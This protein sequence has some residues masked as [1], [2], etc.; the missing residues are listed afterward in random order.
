MEKILDDVFS[1]ENT[2]DSFN[3]ANIE[4]SYQRSNVALCWYA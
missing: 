1:W 3:P 2:R 4:N